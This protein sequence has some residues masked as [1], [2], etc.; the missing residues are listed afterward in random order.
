MALLEIGIALL[1]ALGIVLTYFWYDARLR[2][3]CLDRLKS[4]ADKTEPFQPS[5]NIERFPQR[6]RFLPVGIS[7]SAALVLYFVIGL[8]LP[9]VAAFGTM[10]AVVGY[11]I[12]SLWAARQM[13]LIELQ[14][15]D[16]I[17]VVV[18]ALRA[19]TTLVAAM[20]TALRE[21]PEPLAPY[22]RE[23]IGRIRLGVDPQVAVRDLANH[24]PLETFRLFSLTLAAQWWTGG[25]M[26]STLSRVGRTIRD[27][28]ELTRRIRS[29]SVEAELS[30]IGVM[31]ISY[32]VALIVWRANPVPL[33]GFLKSTLGMQVAAFAV[34]LQA[35]GLV[36]ISKLSRIRY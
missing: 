29:Q 1:L 8:P 23:M 16:A 2:R 6:H 15:A 14:L 19:G 30:V 10:I 24:V 33:V 27:R 35:I 32:V 3:R 5:E 20:D 4:P 22:L 18:G 28:I 34:G 12:E 7:G 13:A 25:S 17:D 9:F 11:L 31:S 21:T 36:W 26:S